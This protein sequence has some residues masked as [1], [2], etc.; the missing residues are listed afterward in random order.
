M[1][2]T[3]L[4]TF[5]S[6]YFTYLIAVVFTSYL[7]YEDLNFFISSPTYTS[8]TE[9]RIQ[10]RHFPK[11][12]LCPFPIMDPSKLRKYGYLD[13]YSYCKG[14]IE[15]SNL[16]GWC[17]NYSDPVDLVIQDISIL[18]SIKDCPKLGAILENNIEGKVDEILHF[19]ITN[20]LFPYGRCCESIIPNKAKKSKL[21]KIYY[22]A[23]VNNSLGIAKGFNMFLTS[24][25]MFH[26][27]DTNGVV[28]QSSKNNPGLHYFEVTL[29]TVK[30]LEKDP[31]VLC[32]IYSEPSDYAEVNSILKLFIS[33]I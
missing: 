29:R 26:Y 2:R 31:K 4:L 23:L 30:K 27:F 13:A 24:P 20:L 16:R 33:N 11:I 22:E 6:K 25:E 12:L 21:L 15:A 3:K 14:K 28:F 17:C 19:E 9:N 10:P 32:R 1:R 5:L 7:I 18:K 8:N